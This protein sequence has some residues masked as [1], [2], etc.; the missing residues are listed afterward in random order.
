MHPALAVLLTQTVEHRAYT[1]QDAYGKPTYGA[2]V[3]RRCRIEYQVQTVGNQQGQE[4]T[5]NTA[6]YFDGTFAVTGRDTLLLPDGT[7]PAIQQVQVWED[8]L[9]P[10]V[11]D[12]V[13]V[14]L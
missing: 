5:S 10:G 4:R 9:Q 1:G 12:H 6:L 11:I 14:V 3:T 7:A 13:K 8:P 2:P